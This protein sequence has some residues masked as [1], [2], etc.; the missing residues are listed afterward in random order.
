MNVPGEISCTVWYNVHQPSFT[1]PEM[2]GSYSVEELRDKLDLGIAMSGG[3]MRAVCLSLG[4]TRT[5][6]NLGILNKA[7]Y[8]SS[9]SG[10][11]WMHGPLSF[12]NKTD[13]DGL[14]KFF[15]SFIPPEN[16]HLETMDRVPPEHSHEYAIYQSNLTFKAFKEYISHTSEQENDHRDFWSKAV[17]ACFFDHYGLGEPGAFLGALHVRGSLCSH[18]HHLCDYTHLPYPII[19][20]SIAVGGDR[21]HLPVEFTPLYY[22]VPGAIVEADSDE[23]DIFPG[24]YLTRSFGFLGNE[25][26]QSAPKIVPKPISS[27]STNEDAN[28]TTCN[29]P[30]PSRLV[31]V[32]EASGLSSSVVAY[33]VGCKLGDKFAQVLHFP[34]LKCWNPISGQVTERRIVD[35]TA[36]DNSGVVALLRRNVT[37]IIACYSIYISVHDKKMEAMDSES[38]SALFGRTACSEG[39]FHAKENRHLQVFPSRHWDV[40]VAGLRARSTAGYGA[41]FLLKTHVLPNPGMGVRGCY[42]AKILFVLNDDCLNWRK[43]IPKD[44]QDQ[45]EADK[46]VGLDYDLGCEIGGTEANLKHF[47]FIPTGYTNYSTRLVNCLTQMASWQM[48]QCSELI[49]ELVKEDDPKGQPSNAMNSA[50]SSISSIVMAGKCAVAEAHSSLSLGGRGGR[51]FTD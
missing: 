25:V 1:Y 3:G 37:R 51:K 39:I 47:P 10:G 40:L 14:N 24:G 22:G 43:Q 23:T 32:S 34:D 20:A 16:C 29:I 49:T 26:T 19:N 33:V 15:G 6:H 28:M 9:I 13:R 31:S 44:L 17:G 11:S 48:H 27:Y 21:G 45:F 50:L 30:N 8:M 12:L 4:W 36:C 7:R 41:S 5:L 35:G 38:I 42:N 2:S 18:M 46:E